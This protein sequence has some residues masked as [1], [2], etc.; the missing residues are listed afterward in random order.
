[1]HV[2]VQEV[3]E[4]GRP[5]SIV[6]RENISDLTMRARNELRAQRTAEDTN[7]MS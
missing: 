2:K 7:S 3:V 4:D 1:M 5:V 6:L